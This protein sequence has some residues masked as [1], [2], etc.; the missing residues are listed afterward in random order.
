[1]GVMNIRPQVCCAVSQNF[2]AIGVD[3]VVGREECMFACHMRRNWCPPDCHVE[4]VDFPFSTWIFQCLWWDG[5]NSCYVEYKTYPIARLHVLFS[6]CFL[7]FFNKDHATFSM[8]SHFSMTKFRSSLSYSRLGDACSLFHTPGHH[9]SCKLAP[10]F[11][12]SACK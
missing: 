2:H 11:E 12:W 9:H 1:M 5:R 6:S 4:T 8:W 7:S 10:V 3:T